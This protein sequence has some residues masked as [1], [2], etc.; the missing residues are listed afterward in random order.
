MAA[1]RTDT[2]AYESATRTP[3]SRTRGFLAELWADK[4]RLR[5][6]LMIWGVALIAFACLVFYLT[7]GRYV[8]DGRFLCPCQQADGLD[9]CFR[10][11][12]GRQCP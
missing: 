10:P 11:G 8:G 2:L 3:G 6:L 5:R 9:R 12:A 4:A 7:G 1:L